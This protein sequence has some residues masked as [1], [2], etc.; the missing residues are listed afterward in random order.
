[1]EEYLYKTDQLTTDTKYQDPPWPP[2]QKP[3]IDFGN[4]AATDGSDDNA[5]A[6]RYSQEHRN[7]GNE[8]KNW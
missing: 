7:K 8:A 2:P 1:M 5:S 3:G 6:I 4:L